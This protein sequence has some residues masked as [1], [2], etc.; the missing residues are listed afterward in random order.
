MRRKSTIEELLSIPWAENPVVESLRIPFAENNPICF[1][2]N[3][4][5][6]IMCNTSGNR[7]HG[8]S[9]DPVRDYST[10]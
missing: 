9:E 2:G 3:S 6:A 10:S 5:L 1:T 4:V 8:V 7:V